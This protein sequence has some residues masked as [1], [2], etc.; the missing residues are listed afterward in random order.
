MQQSPHYNDVVDEV[1]NF[2]VERVEHCLQQGIDKKQLIIDPGFGFGKTLAHNIQL[3]KALEQF[4]ALEMPVLVGASRKSMIGQITGKDTA[5][6]LSGSLA[7]ATLAVTQGAS[8]VRV[9]DV[10]ETVDAIKVAQ[11]LSE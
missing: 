5:Q 11:A 9:H 10:A 3:F 7:L 4:I 6:R 8:I 2:L 1:K